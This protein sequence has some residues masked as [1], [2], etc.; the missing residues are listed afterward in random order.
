MS[1]ANA[2]GAFCVG[3][4]LVLNIFRPAWLP[5]AEKAFALGG[6]MWVVLPFFRDNRLREMWSLLTEAPRGEGG[7]EEVRKALQKRMEDE[8]QSFNPQDRADTRLGLL[9]LVLS[10]AIGVLVEG[11]KLLAHD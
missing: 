8:L 1:R 2:V 9:L 5:L 10:F 11:L 3:L 6:A 4:T 7:A